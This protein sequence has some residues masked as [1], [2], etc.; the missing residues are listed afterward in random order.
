MVLVVQ[1]HWNKFGKSAHSWIPEMAMGKPQKGVFTVVGQR[2]Q[3]PVVRPGLLVVPFEEVV[4]RDLDVQNVS[5]ARTDARKRENP[6]ND[7][8]TGAG[9]RP[10]GC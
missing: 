10:C 3:R 5:L 7:P 1:T 9:C 8:R 6:R 4:L 2:V